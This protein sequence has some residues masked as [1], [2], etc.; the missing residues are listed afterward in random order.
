MTDI[1]IV[2][3]GPAGMTAAIY[4]SRAGK[5]V[6]VIE[7]DSVGG[8]IIYSPLVENYPGI[9]RMAGSDFAEKLQEQ[10]DALG[11]ETEYD[12]ITS[13][14]KGE[15]CVIAKGGED[16][17]AKAVII[18]AG[19]SHKRLGLENEEDLIGCGVSYCAVCDGAFYEGMDV[20]VNGGGN[21][22]LQDALFLSNTCSNV[23]VI[24]R[25]DEFRGDLKLVK[26]LGERPNVSFMLSSVVDA[27]TQNDGELESIIVKDLKTGEKKE[28]PVKG[29]FIAVGQV[30]QTE[31]FRDVFESDSGGYIISDESMRSSVSGVF[32]AGDCR[33]KEVRQLTTAAADGAIAALSACRYVDSI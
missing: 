25:R 20:A 6:K 15:G 26:Q 7:K 13:I 31:G 14:E 30:P 1:V 2:G 5:T 3:G 12:E 9:P 32:V 21:T 23:T 28:L 33:A 24:H 27:L 11:V 17:A 16:H 29:L 18:A 4:A 8:Q 22:A 10:V 19:A